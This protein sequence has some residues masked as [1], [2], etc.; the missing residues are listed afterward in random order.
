MGVLLVLN[1]TLA[2]GAFEIGSLESAQH[3]LAVQ[4]Q[5]LQQTVALQESPE[6]LQARAARLGMVPAA[7][8][9]F[10]RLADGAVLGDPKA[11]TG[12]RRTAS[13]VAAVVRVPAHVTP[14]TDAA[15]AD[16][17]SDGAVADSTATN[18]AGTG[19]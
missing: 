12:V 4:E 15:V 3:A 11:A 17:P 2:Q 14:S 16:T 19:R 5:Q 9:V 13:S 18:A 6:A 10:L 8:P 7:S 1:T